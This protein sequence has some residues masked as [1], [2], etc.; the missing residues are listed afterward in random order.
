MWLEEQVSLFE[1]H[2]GGTAYG[3]TGKPVSYHSALRTHPCNHISTIIQLKNLDPMHP[4]YTIMKKNL[5]SK[6]PCYTPAGV[7]GSRVAGKTEV[8]SRTP[9]MQLDFDY[10]DICEYDVEKLK[11]RVFNLPFIAACIMSSGGY[12]FYA[13][14]VIA[15]PE[16]LA[17]YAEHCFNVLLSAYGIKADRSKGKNVTD[18]RYL[19]YDA[20]MLIREN[21]EPLLISQFMPKPAPAQS[22]NTNA[23]YNSTTAGEGLVNAELRSLSQVAIGGR[24]AAVQKAAYTLG[25]LG[26]HDVLYQINDCIENTASFAGEEPKY[27]KC[28]R[29]CFNAGFQKPL[30]KKL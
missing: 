22:S 9:I 13:L 21:P 3:K 16:K 10:Q 11:Q 29:D 20:N 12:G 25:G 14:A 8:I 1:S 24:W 5:K 15:E 30:I 6:L 23:R 27:L 28:A 17:E 26:L 7:I 18:L 2:K 4:D 19:S